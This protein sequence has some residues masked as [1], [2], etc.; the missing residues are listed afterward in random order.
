MRQHHLQLLYD[1]SLAEPGPG[2]WAIPK[3]CESKVLMANRRQGVFFDRDGVLNELV[4]NPTTAA[5]ESPHVVSDLHLCADVLLPLRQLYEQGFDLFIVSNQPS[6]A[7]GKTS[8]EAIQSIAQAFED[9][10]RREGVIFRH[11][12]YCY[13]HQQGIVPKYSGPC[14]CRKPEPYF[15]LVAAKCYGIDLKQSWMIGDRTSDVEC[16]QR[17]GCRTILIGHA[18]LS[19]D[20]GAS[21]PDYIV[22]DVAAAAAV[23]LREAGR[24]AIKRGNDDVAH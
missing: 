18:H 2:D 16:G 15:L 6:Y 24:L 20:A 8:L 19:P 4:W 3:A 14:V 17:A 10:F 5:Y 12:Y 21:K 1:V 11:S 9:Q 7:K 13:H 23:I 22:E